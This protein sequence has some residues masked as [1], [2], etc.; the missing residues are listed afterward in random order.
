MYNEGF[1]LHGLKIVFLYLQQIIN[2]NMNMVM[3]R[4]NIQVGV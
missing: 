2:V 4:G 1:N 3:D